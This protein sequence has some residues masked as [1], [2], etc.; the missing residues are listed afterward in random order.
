MSDCEKV[1]RAEKDSVIYLLKKEKK[2]QKVASV[3]CRCNTVDVLH[4]DSGSSDRR[5]QAARQM[6]LN[7]FNW[8]Q[9]K[10]P[11]IRPEWDSYEV[12]AQPAA[13]AH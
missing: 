7:L 8:P 5:P 13:T 11:F 9:R 4:R 3:N 12:S 1:T 10:R 2:G 6:R